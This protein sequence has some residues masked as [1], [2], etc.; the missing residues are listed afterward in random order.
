[1]ITSGS[2]PSSRIEPA[3][4]TSTF[5]KTHSRMM[6][7]FKTPDG[8]TTA[9]IDATNGKRAVDGCPLVVAETFLSG[10]EPA[11]C[12]EH[13]GLSH[14]IQNWWQRLRDWIER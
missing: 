3:R 9:N 6:P 1:M 13:S 4:T 11:P 14:R 7:D 8:I 2:G 10:T 12:D 5:A